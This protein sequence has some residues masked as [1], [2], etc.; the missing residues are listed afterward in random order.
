MIRKYNLKYE[1]DLYIDSGIY[2]IDREDSYIKESEKL[3][4]CRKPHICVCCQQDIQKGEY[5]VCETVI[6]PGEGRKSAYTCTKCIEEWL[7]ESGQIGEL[8][9]GR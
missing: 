2:G 6:F 8:E 3:V 9:E 4:K 7:E 1:T 5:A